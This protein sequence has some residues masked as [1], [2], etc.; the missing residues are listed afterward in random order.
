ME[1]KPWQED[2][3]DNREEETRLERRHRKQKGKGVVANRVLTIL[4]SLF[5]VI[6]VAMV[7]VLIYLSTGGSN[8]TAALKDFYD[9]SAPSSTSKVEESSSSTSKAQETKESTPS[10]SSSEEHTDGEGTLTVQPGEGEAA[11]AQRAGISIAQL[12]ALNPSHMSSGT[13]FANPGDV[14]KTR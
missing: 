4:A 14:I 6:V 12:E 11:L 7:V 1:K 9:S 5:F 8:R 13:W 10:E 2:I 3:Y